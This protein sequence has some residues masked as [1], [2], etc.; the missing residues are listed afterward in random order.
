MKFVTMSVQLEL[1][2]T[3]LHH[4]VTPKSVKFQPDARF[5]PKVQWV[6]KAEHRF[7]LGISARQSNKICR[8]PKRQE[9][10]KTV[11]F[12]AQLRPSMLQRFCSTACADGIK[13]FVSMPSHRRKFLVLEALM[14]SDVWC[15]N[16]LVPG[17]A[18]ATGPI[19]FVGRKKLLGSATVVAEVPT[20]AKGGPCQSKAPEAG[21]WVENR[22]SQCPIKCLPF[23]QLTLPPKSQKMEIKLCITW[24]EE[25]LTYISQKV[26]LRLVRVNVWCLSRRKRLGAD[27]NRRPWRTNFHIWVCLKYTYAIQVGKLMINYQKKLKHIKNQWI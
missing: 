15:A 3:E 20:L 19:Q 13:K 16:R 9:F 27:E 14:S 6:G 10:R 18:A 25:K 7:V 21:T 22:V 8:L 23:L 17:R 1:E 5:T 2:A 4:A 12:Y 24:D 11:R 26:C